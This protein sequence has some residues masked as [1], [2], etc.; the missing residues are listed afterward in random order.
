VQEEGCNDGKEGRRRRE[1][2]QSYCVRAGIEKAS[3]KENEEKTN[4]V[5]G[6]VHCTSTQHE[7]SRE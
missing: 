4:R 3:K 7:R 6:L 2:A 5:L 1:S